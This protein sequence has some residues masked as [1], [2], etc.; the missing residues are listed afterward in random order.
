MN[1]NMPDPNFLMNQVSLSGS[2]DYQRM[3]NFNNYPTNGGTINNG[4][5]FNSGNMFNNN[6]IMFNNGGAFNN[7]NS[8]YTLN[9][10]GSS[11]YNYNQSPDKWLLGIGAAT[12]IFSAI[13][14]TIA[15]NKQSEAQ[16]QD[17]LLQYQAYQQQSAQLAKQQQK[18]QFSESMQSMFQMMMMMKQFENQA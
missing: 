16:Q 18:Q 8:N 9:A 6:G 3:Y 13:G 2:C 1:L 5:M 14:T 7:T 4:T 10:D 17:Q 15:A 12:N 11:S